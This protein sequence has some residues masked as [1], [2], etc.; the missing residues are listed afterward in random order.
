MKNATPDSIVQIHAVAGMNLCIRRP[1]DIMLA[2]GLIWP[3]R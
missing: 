3:L 2:A 1:P